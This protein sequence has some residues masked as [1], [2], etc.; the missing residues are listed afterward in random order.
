[1]NPSAINQGTRPA[2]RRLVGRRSGDER[3]HLLARELGGRG[4]KRN[5]IPASRAFNRIIMREPE[6]IARRELERGNSII[7]EAIPQ[8]VKGQKRAVAVYLR[9]RRV[10]NGKPS[11]VV[12]DKILR[13]I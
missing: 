10:Q 9:I 4:I 5:L 7:Y 3:T 11:A 8:Y 2:A 1:M 13:D 12:F 6:R